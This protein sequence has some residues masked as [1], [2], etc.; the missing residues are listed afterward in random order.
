MSTFVYTFVY[1]F[2]RESFQVASNEAQ[3][4]TIARRIAPGLIIT[5]YNQAWRVT[6]EASGYACS[7]LFSRLKD[8]KMSALKL[9]AM[10]NWDRPM[11]EIDAELQAK[12]EDF[13]RELRV[14]GRESL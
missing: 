12:G 1:T 5:K 3:H 14:A 11:T 8:A 7:Q 4:T 10:V 9:A 13:R 6:H 2:S